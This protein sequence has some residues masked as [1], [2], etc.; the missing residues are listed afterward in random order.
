MALD[1]DKPF[2][3]EGYDLMAA[4]FEV[5]RQLGGGLA[6]EIY[7][8][9]LEIEL[10]LRGIVF[11]AKP[12][13]P[14]YYRSNLLRTHYRPDFLVVDSI[15]LELKSVSGLVP[16]HEGQLF[17]YMRITRKPVGYLVNFAP[18]TKVEWKR[19]VLSEYL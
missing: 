6:E 19:F 4:V 18:L 1:A 17:N 15:L 14:V 13:L 8:Q 7:Q 12:K 10:R 2:A 16:D 9:S 3:K 5:H 11:L